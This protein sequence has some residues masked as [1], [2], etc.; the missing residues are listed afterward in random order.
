MKTLLI[1]RHAKYDSKDDDLPD[2]DR[3]LDQRG[4]ETAPRVGEMMRQENI[5]PDLILSSTAKRARHTAE[6]AAQSLGYK[7]EI[8]LLSQF[9]AAPSETYIRALSGIDDRYESV[10]VVGHNPGLEDLVQSLTYQVRQMPTAALACI[11]L[12][13]RHWSEISTHPHGRLTSIWKPKEFESR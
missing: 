6:L 13:I 12:P 8:K 5:L 3:P 4:Q 7:G 1:L 2:H 9:Y 10:M 11:E